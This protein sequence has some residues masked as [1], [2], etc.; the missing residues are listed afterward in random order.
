M[1]PPAIIGYLPAFQ[2]GKLRCCNNGIESQDH[3][4]HPRAV[5]GR[6]LCVEAHLQVLDFFELD[7]DRPPTAKLL[8]CSSNQ[9][10][11]QLVKKDFKKRAM[12]LA[13]PFVWIGQLHATPVDC[14]RVH[15]CIYNNVYA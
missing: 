8:P 6:A 13:K 12:P 5:L 3:A 1:W 7:G 2:L 4:Y 14:Q 9:I 15:P 10:A 11:F